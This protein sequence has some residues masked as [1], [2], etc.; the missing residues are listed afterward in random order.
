MI[1]SSY[2]LGVLEIFRK[3]PL[4]PS[5][6]SRKLLGKRLVL[7]ELDQEGFVQEVLYILVVVEGGGR[8]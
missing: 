8:R 2:R 6:C 3:R 1:Q 4:S 7:S 5:K